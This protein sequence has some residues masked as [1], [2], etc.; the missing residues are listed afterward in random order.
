[1]LVP[2]KT[3]IN[4]IISH[5]SH[6]RR[7]SSHCWAAALLESISSTSSHHLAS[8]HCQKFLFS[9]TDLLLLNITCT[10]SGFRFYIL[11]LHSK[12]FS[13]PLYPWCGPFPDPCPAGHAPL[14]YHR[15]PNPWLG[16]PSTALRGPSFTGDRRKN[17]NEKSTANFEKMEKRR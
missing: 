3:A 7:E 12:S 10:C 8:L 11:L 17:C 14:F 9:L 15:P 4:V 1:M 5:S 6:C 16:S 13:S 2:T